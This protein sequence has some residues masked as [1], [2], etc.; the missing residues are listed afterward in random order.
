MG[1]RRCHHHPDT[2][3][4]PGL[5]SMMDSGCDVHFTK[6]RCWKS[7]EDGKELDMIRS[8]GVFF[9]SARLANPTS[10]D[11]STLDLNPMTAAEVEQAA[12]VREDAA[13]GVPGGEAKL[14]GD[15][16]PTLRI[17]VPAG[18][19][20]PSAEETALHEASGRH[21][22]YG[23]WCQWCIAARA[24]DKPKLRPRQGSSLILQSLDERR[25]KRGR[26]QRGRCRLRELVSH[27]VSH[28]S[29]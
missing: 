15:G 22:P 8:R 7:K 10:R 21:V 23:N 29:F 1:N 9:V 24:A 20:T 19:A 3:G 17:K 13:F 27:T 6:D 28:E 5:G 25:I 12:L 16:E 11:A 2:T 4:L 26:S 14:D 18:P